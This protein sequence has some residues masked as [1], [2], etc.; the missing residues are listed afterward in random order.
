MNSSFFEFQPNHMLFED[1]PY[2]TKRNSSLTKKSRSKTK[3]SM[4]LAKIPFWLLPKGEKKTIIENF[5]DKAKFMPRKKIILDRIKVR[6]STQEVKRL[7]NQKKKAKKPAANLAEAFKRMSPKK[8]QGCNSPVKRLQEIQI[9]IRDMKTPERTSVLPSL[10][11][12]NSKTR[13]GGFE[14]LWNTAKSALL[15]KSQKQMLG[16]ITTP[17]RFKFSKKDQG[18]YSR[19]NTDCGTEL[20]LKLLNGK[21]K[22]LNMKIPSHSFNY[23]EAP[24]KSSNIHEDSTQWK[25]DSNNSNK[26]FVF[27]DK[28]DLRA[29]KACKRIDKLLTKFDKVLQNAKC[30]V[31]ESGKLSKN[32]RQLKMKRKIAAYKDVHG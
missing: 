29:E 28:S 2:S 26:E 6:A 8:N 21:E 23:R 27:V 19:K 12:I 14:E 31:G 13:N 9:K 7:S 32:L 3:E 5:K 16:Q 18:Y 25:S 24:L 17:K 11:S 4:L 22:L 1:T 10:T 15:Y 20:K 30:F